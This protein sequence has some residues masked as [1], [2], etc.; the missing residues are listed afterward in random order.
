[1]DPDQAE[2]VGPDFDLNCLTLCW[3]GSNEWILETK[4]NKQ[5]T[6]DKHAKS[7]VGKEVIKH[8]ILYS[9]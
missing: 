7:P 6:T 8:D 1:M 2:N 3:Q 5:Q 4:H 9:N